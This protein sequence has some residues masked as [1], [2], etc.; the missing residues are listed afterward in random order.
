M[1]AVAGER[2]V[3]FTALPRFSRLAAVC[4]AVLAVTG[5]LG[6]TARIGAVSELA[7]AYGALLFA[8]TACLLVAGVLGALTRRR[9]RAGRTPVLVWAGVEVLVLAVAVGLAGTLSQ[10]A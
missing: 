7:S 4:I 3:L 2:D 6:A 8:K 10:T 5:V 1:L 9:L